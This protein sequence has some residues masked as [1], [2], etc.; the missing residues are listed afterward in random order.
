MLI[1]VAWLSGQAAF[2]QIQY[3]D[4]SASANINCLNTTPDRTGGGVIIFDYNNDGLEDFYCAGGNS[5]DALYKNNGDGTF[6][7]VITEAGISN[8]VPKYTHGG[9]A[10]DFNKDGWTD[11]YVSCQNGG[12]ILYKNNGNGTFTNISKD[13]GIFSPQGVNYNISTTFADFDGDSYG[14][15]YIARWIDTAIT[16]FDP[17]LK[18]LVYDH[19]GLPNWLFLNNGG[20]SFREAGHELGVDNNA[21]T[22]VCN[23]FD[24]DLDGDMDILVGNDFGYDIKPNALYRNL[25]METG[26]L[27]FEDVSHATGF[28]IRAFCMGIGPGDFDHDGDFDFY[29]TNIG[30]E[31]LLVNDGGLFHNEAK[32]R[33]V[34]VGRFPDDTAT[35]TT[36]WSSIF[37]DMDNDGWEDLY[38]VHGTQ[39]ISYPWHT[40]EWDTTIFFKNNGGTF[41]NA[42][43]T[44]GFV[45]VE[46]GKAGAC[47]DFNKD[48][49]VDLIFGG[50]DNTPRNK[51]KGYHLLENVSP[52][53]NNYVEFKLQGVNCIK[54]A[55]G[56]T[57]QVWSNGVRHLRQVSTGGVYSSTNSLIQHVGIG[58][59]TKIDS[60]VIM[61][62]AYRPTEGKPTRT[63]ERY[64][65]LPVNQLITLKEG[66]MASVAMAKGITQHSALYP[67]V[68]SASIHLT[69]LE[70][71][72]K[73]E[74]IDQ[75]GRIC[76]S[77]RVNYSASIPVATLPSGWYSVRV[78]SSI[79][80]DIHHFVKQ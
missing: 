72:S 11:L 62:P 39:E 43:S 76:Y 41:T 9:V 75:L 31:F 28:D 12:D 49:K 20:E 78:S 80:S 33:G 65:D 74:I 30:E 64:Y 79:G 18:R 25:L 67:T 13:A 52:N 21:P 51:S 36:S 29:A 44:S 3:K 56:A 34:F 26:E 10:F 32:E 45:T 50:N 63:I 48:G 47:L 27:K 55:I 46:R 73:V 15:I 1:V 71:N 66:Q 14:D 42:T 23:A 60:L 37:T 68:T 16:H 4:I 22:L 58:A 2:A 40:S 77:A 54:E 70:Q 69:N 5:D 24:Y 61:W 6:T 57:L 8:H 7:N 38:V 19:K 17:D 59:A 35:S 53:T